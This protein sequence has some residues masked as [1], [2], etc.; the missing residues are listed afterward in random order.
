[1][2]APTCE[3]QPQCPR[4]RSGQVG[5]ESVSRLLSQP[6]YAGYIVGKAYGF[7]WLKAQHEALISLESSQTIQDRRVGRTKA[8]KR[9][10]IVNAFALRSIVCCAGCDVP[11]RSSFSG[12]RN[13]TR[14]RY[15]L[16]QTKRCEAN[17]NPIRRDKLEGGVGE[18]LKRL[19]PPPAR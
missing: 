6:L 14:H 15:Y 10:N 9:D 11:R 18:L 2:F 13:G 4:A 8:P 3:T 17:G 19:E 1:M 5:P 7:N 16:C 12:I